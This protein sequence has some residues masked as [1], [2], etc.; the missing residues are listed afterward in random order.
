PIP[1][2]PM[3]HHYKQT[4]TQ[5]NKIKTKTEQPQQQPTHK[6][7]SVVRQELASPPTTTNKEDA[8]YQT[9]KRA[10]ANK[11]ESVQYISTDDACD[12]A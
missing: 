12:R 4:S 2:N 1:N 7:Q 6:R 10:T 11:S 9:R 5:K 8:Q 3:S